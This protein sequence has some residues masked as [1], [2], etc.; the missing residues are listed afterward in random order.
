MVFEQWAVRL[1]FQLQLQLQTYLD[2]G[3]FKL[4]TLDHS[5]LVQPDFFA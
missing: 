3:K 5:P 2:I 4:S 1:H